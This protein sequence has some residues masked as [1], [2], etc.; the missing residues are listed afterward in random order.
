MITHL[1]V[2]GAL[3]N[4][5]DE[6]KGQSVYVKASFFSALSLESFLN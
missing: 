4:V 3:K 2:F 6:K 1:M 5:A